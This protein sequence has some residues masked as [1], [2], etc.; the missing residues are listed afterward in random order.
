MRSL[1]DGGDSDRK[2]DL[3]GLGTRRPHRALSGTLAERSA[4][5]TRGLA[6]NLGVFTGIVQRVQNFGARTDVFR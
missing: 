6:G 4:D 3:G 1:F 2:G 5:V